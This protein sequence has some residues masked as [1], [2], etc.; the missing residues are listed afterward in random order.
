MF[1]KL[2]LMIYILLLCD[3][4]SL[5][6]IKTQ[7]SHGTSQLKYV[8]HFFYIRLPVHRPQ[9]AGCSFPIT[10]LVGCFCH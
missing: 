10:K 4:I 2:L 8:L 1:L 9:D 3:A 7:S 5:A 6:H